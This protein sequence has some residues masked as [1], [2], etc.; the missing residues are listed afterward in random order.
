[1]PI[2]LVIAM[3]AARKC[4]SSA[5]GDAVRSRR[6][7]NQYG[8]YRVLSVVLVAGDSCREPDQSNRSQMVQPQKR[9]R[10]AFC[11]ALGTFS[12]TFGIQA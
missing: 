4:I 12:N 9:R 6:V 5:L 8:L 3:S 10:T 1:M 7:A 11:D 2:F